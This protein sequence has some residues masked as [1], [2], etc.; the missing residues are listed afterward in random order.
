MRYEFD[1]FSFD[2]DARRLT[3]SGREVHLSG[4]AIDLLRLLIEQR[5]RV[6]NK[7]DLHDALWPDTFVVESSLPVLVRELRNALGDSRHAIRTVH[8]F[9]Y[10]FGG[11][12]RES[13]GRAGSPIAA[14]HQ[15]RYAAHVFPLREGK[16]VIGRD[17]AA[18]VFIAS[19]SVSRQHAAITVEAERAT[20]EDLE[21]K[22]G[23]RLD[24]VLIT[25]PT[26]LRSAAAIRLGAVE[27]LYSC[28]HPNV[29]TET[30]N[31]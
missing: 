15:L 7:R 12:A 17:P 25:R 14:A 5:P 29:D 3:S 1:S 19:T 6:V 13:L 18:D 31:E 28:V 2:T 27:L 8:G 20:I 24:G 9:G 4:K 21:S 30:V 16:N 11:D 10:A 22:N 26:L 23:T